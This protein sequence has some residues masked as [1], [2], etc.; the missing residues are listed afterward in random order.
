MTGVLQ[1]GH[2]LAAAPLLTIRLTCLLLKHT[3][4]ERT[5][6]PSYFLVQC[7]VCDCKTALLLLLTKTLHVFPLVCFNDWLGTTCFP[8][9]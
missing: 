1:P 7:V 9:K 4:W 3:V 2:A 6:V 8:R 5:R